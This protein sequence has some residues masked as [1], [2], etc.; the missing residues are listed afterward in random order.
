MV[1]GIYPYISRGSI[2]PEYPII[3]SLTGVSYGCEI[4][5]SVRQQSHAC[6]SYTIFRIHAIDEG[7]CTS[8]RTQRKKQLVRFVIKICGERQTCLKLGVI[9]NNL[10]CVWISVANLYTVFSNL[11]I[12]Y[13]N[14]ERLRR[15]IIQRKKRSCQYRKRTWLIIKMVFKTEDVRELRTYKCIL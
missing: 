5:L 4:H 3:V 6:D 7:W 14:R 1:G 11:I 15:I 13:S 2:L 8:H 9:T 12:R 10:V